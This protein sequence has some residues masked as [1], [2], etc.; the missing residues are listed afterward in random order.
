MVTRA[1]EAVDP[2]ATFLGQTI[3]GDGMPNSLTAEAWSLCQSMQNDG[4]I[5]FTVLLE[6]NDDDISTTTANG[7]KQYCSTDPNGG[8]HFFELT[9]TQV[10][11]LAN[12]FTSIG[13]SIATLRLVQ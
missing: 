5:M 13:N 7:Y 12:V 8:A 4:I 10:S 6:F 9:G 3:G 11:Q 1:N 2:P